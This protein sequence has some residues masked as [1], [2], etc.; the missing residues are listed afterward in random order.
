MNFHFSAFSSLVQTIKD[1]LPV[2]AEQEITWSG[3]SNVRHIQFMHAVRNAITH[4]G[5]PVINL[6]ADGRYYVACDFLRLDQHQRP[7][8]VQ[9]PI[10][11]IETLVT[12]FTMDL[13]KH[14]HS[15]VSPLLGSQAL[16]G[17]LYGSDFFDSA[18]NHPAI[19]KFAQRLYAK[20]DRLALDRG[21][22]NP[23]AE[24]LSELDALISFCRCQQ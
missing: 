5:N 3:L 24:V 15:A 21:N 6:W 22:G 23:V 7:I 20:T 1:I 8:Q 4:D 13:C 2:V 19:P 10:E 16:A 17:P 18:I 9:A 14:L 11:D 12:Q